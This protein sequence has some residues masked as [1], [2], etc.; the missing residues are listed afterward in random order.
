MILNE[1]TDKIN[2]SANPKV[3]ATRIA[4]QLNKDD[5]FNYYTIIYTMSDGY[6]IEKF[7]IKGMK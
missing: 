5:P 6:I 2:S 3:T 4:Y 7:G 1:Y